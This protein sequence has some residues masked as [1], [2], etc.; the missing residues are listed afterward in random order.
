MTRVM[1]RI[2]PK[3]HG[4]P[5]TLDEF[6]EAIGQEGY[7]YELSRGII[8]VTNVPNPKHMALVMALR[9]QLVVYKESRPGQIY[10]VAAGSECKVL[11]QSLQSER[12]PD[13]A[14]YRTGPPEGDEVWSTWVP[15]L[16]AEIVSPRSKK[17]DYVEKREEYLA[18]GIKEYWIINP[19]RRELLALRRYR[20]TWKE[21][22]VKA[23]E[24]YRT[25]LFPGLVLD[26]GR[27]F[28]NGG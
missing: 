13:V 25:P 8:T 20:G 17:R 4:R 9:D 22:T 3:D 16:V 27:V 1:T 11:L 26:V 14:V 12:H 24:K 28:K 19:R 10:G 6:D 2:G 21:T 7:L 23:G 5:M 18:F 15:E